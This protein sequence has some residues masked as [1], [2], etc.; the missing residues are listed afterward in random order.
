MSKEIPM[1]FARC[2]CRVLQVAPL[3]TV[4][5][6]LV[7]GSSSLAQQS[8]LPLV[9]SRSVAEGSD[10]PAPAEGAG[11][12]ERRP[13]VPVSK[14]SPSEVASIGG[15]TVGA[16]HIFGY[17]EDCSLR[18]VGF[19]YVRNSFGHFSWIRI[20]YMAEVI[21]LIQLTEPALYD[22]YA[23]PVGTEKTTIN[24][25]DVVPAG[26]RLLF[27]PESRW[28]PYLVGAGGVAYFSSPIL[29]PQ[30]TR[31]NFSAEFGGG[32]QVE[33]NQRAGLRFGYSTFHLS[34][35]NTGQHNPALDTNLIYIGTVFHLRARGEER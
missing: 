15:R 1:H 13:S 34:N 18:M 26:A 27:A 7:A 33:I 30:A 4:G 16:L 14:F 32:V 19:Q 5:A 25:A 8:E 10:A 31:L 3:L 12:I 21:P 23:N 20:D 35:G 24:G 11:S 28:K 29:S 9:A 17:A 6:M 22:Q 2:G